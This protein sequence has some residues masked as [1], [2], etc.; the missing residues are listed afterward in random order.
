MSSLRRQY[1]GVSDVLSTLLPVSLQRAVGVC[2]WNNANQDNILHKQRSTVRD[3][4]RSYVDMTAPTRTPTC[5]LTPHSL[6]RDSINV[7]TAMRTHRYGHMPGMKICPLYA[8]IRDWEES[9]MQKCVLW[10]C[11]LCEDVCRNSNSSLVETAVAYQHNILNPRNKTHKHQTATWSYVST[12]R[13]TW[14]TWT[15]N[16]PVDKHHR[17]IGGWPAENA[18]RVQYQSATIHSHVQLH[19]ARRKCS[20]SLWPQEYARG[21]DPN[22]TLAH[23]CA[24]VFVIGPCT[25]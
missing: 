24:D 1:S 10:K 11:D 7:Y 16:L 15:S 9:V 2:T 17:S 25:N 21:Y 4:A 14:T 22:A 3:H 23:W 8:H 18:L 19:Q 5:A 13:I 20:W 12:T 6:I